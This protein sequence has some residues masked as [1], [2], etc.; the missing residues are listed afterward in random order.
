MEIINNLTNS[1]RQ[2]FTYNI[3]GGDTLT[4]TLYYYPT[5]RSWFFDFSYGNYTCNGERVVLT[6]NA[7]RH[8]KNILP[9]GIAFITDSNAEPYSIDDF[10][11]GRIHMGILTQD[12]V[13][14][15]ESEI[16]NV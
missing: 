4:V 9:F 1:A 3:D 8:L 16:Y 2:T 14:T 11:S 5:Q 6:P 10:S 15:I 7:L 12:E 13:N